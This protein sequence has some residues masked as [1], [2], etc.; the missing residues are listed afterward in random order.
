[1]PFPTL[2]YLFFLHGGQN[3]KLRKEGMGEQKGLR[4]QTSKKPDEFGGLR[5]NPRNQATQHY[6]NRV[7]GQVSLQ[8]VD[9]Q[10]T[11]HNHRRQA[12]GKAN[13]RCAQ[14]L[15]KFYVLR[16]LIPWEANE[17][18]QKTHTKGTE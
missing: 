2:F 12:S 6:P 1:L 13:A 15:D 4:Q 5:V 9:H 14:I 8:P 10:A 3:V 11:K 17:I 18:L 7:D 16:V